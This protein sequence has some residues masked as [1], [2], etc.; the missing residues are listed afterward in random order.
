M[1][2]I[3][4]IQNFAFQ[5]NLFPRGSKIIIGVSGGP[6]SVC[7]LNIMTDLSQKYDFQLHI[8]HVNY[9]LRG[10]ES[11]KDED[12][13]RK[14]AEKYGQQITVLRLKKSDY[15]GNL[16]NTLRDI[17]YEFFEKLRVEMAFD[18][19]AIAHN[20][21]DQAETVLMR[22]L[23]GSG[24]EGLSAIKARSDKLIRPLL[25]TSK[26]EILAFN[27]ENKLEFRLDESNK[28]FDFTRNRL[29]HELIPY[30]EKNFNPS[31]KSTLADWSQI[32]A[33]DYEFINQKAERFS[34]KVC[35]NKCSYFL[36]D[37]FLRLHPSIQR[38]ALRNII[39]NLKETKKDIESGQIEEILKIVRSTKKKSPKAFIGGL[40]I[41]KNGD[42]IKIFC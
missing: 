11:D 31:I 35:K 7:L 1:Q 12:L 9:G 20:Q 39:L 15:K 13:V 37:D 22:V 16:E 10:K 2:F 17:R 41:T 36:A 23:R 14:M 3:K 18:L 30:L 5:N 4:T 27:K 25:K 34:S 21:D 8:A 33:E 26:E 32:V 42:K 40:K 28:N 24:L 29:R 19:I 6:D 38:Q